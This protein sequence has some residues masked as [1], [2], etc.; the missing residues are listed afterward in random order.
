MGTLY[1]FRFFD[2]SVESIHDGGMGNSWVKEWAIKN[3][4]TSEV[5][6]VSALNYIVSGT[7]F[8]K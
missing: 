7:E 2:G 3:L 8:F 1:T 5:Y 4:Q 6:Q